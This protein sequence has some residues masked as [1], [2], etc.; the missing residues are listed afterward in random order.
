MKPRF[1]LIRGREFIMKDLYTFDSDEE[2][3]RKT[4]D[5]VNSAYAS[6]FDYL[7]VKWV[8]GQ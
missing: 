1:G 3:S 4:Y 5:L 7:G 6:F 8:K 2:S